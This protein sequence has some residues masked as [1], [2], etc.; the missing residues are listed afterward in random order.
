MVS[1]TRKHPSKDIKILFGK[2]AGHCAFPDCYQQ[3]VVDAND[4][5]N[6]VIVGQIAHIEA[7]S[8]KGPRANLMLTP[9]QRDSYENWILLC[10][11]HHDLVDNQPNTYKSSDLRQW[12][13]NLEKWVES[14]LSENMARINFDEL[15]LVCRGIIG[16]PQL[17]SND[18]EVLNPQDKMQRNEL[19]KVLFEITTGLGKASEVE[20]FIINQ[21]VFDPKF[22]ERLKAGF[23]AE[24]Y[25]LRKEGYTGDALFESLMEFSGG[26]N[27]F[28]RRAA[29]LAVL[30]YLFQKCEIFEK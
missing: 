8:D 18:Y 4:L 12:K 2:S 17:P 14:N 11:N 15:E 1:Q 3:C 5:D 9:K 27:T 28:A 23:L 13:L 20:R 22:P 7:H 10:S 29:G 26:N 16:F 6:A 24:Y 30:V 19:S 21:S 25:K